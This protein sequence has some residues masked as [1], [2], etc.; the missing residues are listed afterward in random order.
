MRPIGFRVS[1]ISNWIS[2]RPK[3]FHTNILSTRVATLEKPPI[4]L[5]PDWFI[6][7]RLKLRHLQL[8]AALD[9]Q[10]NLARAAATLSVTQPAASKLLAE[11]ETMLGT[12][13]FE[14]L[15]RGMEPNLYGEVLVRRA[16]SVLIELEAAA[17][18]LGAMRAGAAGQ[19]TIGA[20]TGPASGPV[21]RAVERMRR[22]RP[23]MAITVQVETSGPLVAKL[24]E[25]RLDFA[26]ARIPPGVDATSLDYREL[27]DEEISLF[28]REDH[29]LLRQGPVSLSM[30]ASLPW[31]LQPPGTLLRRRVDGL[32]RAAG[33]SPPT[34]VLNTE[35]VM[36]SLSV[37]ARG[38]TVTALS[39]SMV[40][41]F[42]GPGGM[43][44][45]LPEL[46]E[47]GRISI[48]T[49]GLI[50]L[51][52]RPLSPAAE[53]LYRAIEAEQQAGEPP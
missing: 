17:K 37:V 23:G 18:E 50:R 9:E 47:T 34:E 29:S 2:L 10:R 26:V 1:G 31:V 16:R 14:R 49:Y 45:K 5:P 40:E 11:I 38:A 6:R 36:L 43:F 15:P 13:L 28:V 35:S 21:V 19:V 12:V 30:L 44:R 8:L 27:A 32:F 41:I 3:S 33:L 48:D 7:A 42:A 4:L 52:E 53:V 24:L 51:S 46:A 22:N 39:R 20:V 25:G